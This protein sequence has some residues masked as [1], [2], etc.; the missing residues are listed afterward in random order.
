[1]VHRDIKPINILITSDGVPKLLDFGIAKI[2]EGT[3]FSDATRSLLHPMTPGYASPEQVRGQTLTTAT[4]I[5]SLGVL[6]YELLTGQ[7]PYRLSGKP[8]DEAIRVICE[9]EPE[10][11]TTLACHRDP[12]TEGRR[13]ALQLSSDLDA[14]VAKAMRKD[15]QQRYASA[16]DLATDIGRSL[17]GLPVSAHC[18]TLLY[19]SGKFVR[20]HRFGVGVAVAAAVVLLGF[21]FAMA[22]QAQRTAKERDRANREAESSKRVAEFM[23]NMFRVSDPNEARGNTVTAREILDKASREIHPGLVKDPELQAQMMDV[24]GLVYRNLGLSSVARPLLEQSVA[25][26]LR[27]LGHENPATLLSQHHL[28]A[29]LDDQGRFAEAEKLEREVLALRRR[30]LGPEHPDTLRSMNNLASTVER[31]SRGLPDGKGKEAREKESEGLQREVLAIRRR[32][33]GPEHADTIASMVNLGS[34]LD[35][36]NRFSE[37]EKLQVETVEIQKRVYGP[38]NPATL[39]SMNNLAFTL[40]H[41]GRYSEAEKIYREV[42]ETQHRVLGPEHPDTLLSMDNLNNTVAEEGRYSE[43]E[44]LC[45]ETLEIRRRVLGRDHPDTATSTYELAG[46]LAR[47]G[48]RD[49]ALKVLREAVDHGLDA[50]TDLDLAKQED[51]KSLQGDT[52]FEALVAHAKERATAQTPRN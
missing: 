7:P 25:I 32:V 42:L 8:L 40:E 35:T 41:L 24:M 48:R 21:A 19:R 18:G 34:T 1:V 30:V 26:R 14:I 49:D 12:A 11:P 22:F 50:G 39:G 38:D 29:V 15:P 44:A 51:F 16:E 20:R 3:S 23:T 43:A 2:V 33:L 9:I 10:K 52:R 47:Q 28:S 36:E 46:L 13:S 37:A 17:D 4:D 27:V 5:Y 6:L 31:E 45:R